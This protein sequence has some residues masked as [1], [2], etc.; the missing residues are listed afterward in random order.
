MDCGGR[1]AVTG[2]ASLQLQPPPPPLPTPR[3]PEGPHGAVAACVVGAG[4]AVGRPRSARTNARPSGRP[5][6]RLVPS[7][8]GQSR[9]PA[10]GSLAR[11]RRAT[12]LVHD[13]PAFAVEVGSRCALCAAEAPKGKRRRELCAPRWDSRH[14]ATAR[15]QPR[16]ASPPP[17]RRSRRRRTRARPQRGRLSTAHAV[18]PRPP[19]A[20]AEGTAADVVPGLGQM[21]QARCREGRGEGGSNDGIQEGRGRW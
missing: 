17:R 21:G 20:R 9:T 5:P 11:S 1:P 10:R 16:R 18:L 7:P 2:S 6:G 8:A 14:G 3:Q 12:A 13:P 19:S 4:V 15:E